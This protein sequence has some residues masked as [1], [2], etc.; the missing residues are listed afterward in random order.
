[1]T[2]RTLAW[3]VSGRVVLFWSEYVAS[4]IPL[5]RKFSLLLYCSNS[6]EWAIAF[7]SV[8]LIALLIVCASSSCSSL[9][10]VARALSIAVTMVFWTS[11]WIFAIKIGIEFSRDTLIVD[12]TVFCIV[13]SITLTISSLFSQ[14]YLGDLAQL[15]FYSHQ[16][17]LVVAL[18][19]A[20]GKLAVD[21]LFPAS[22]FQEFQFQGRQIQW[23]RAFS[24]SLKLFNKFI[25]TIR[26][27][28]YRQIKFSNEKNWQ[29]LTS[30][31]EH[32][33]D[34]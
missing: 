3:D 4:G 19:F 8:L 18:A 10:I 12:Y 9:F 15:R 27:I 13:A 30:K 2:L 28:I 26:L 5:M 22:Q 23:K 31:T 24:T 6:S 17:L 34:L 25:T 16:L 1:M 14:V 32:N 21:Q 11:S 20:P 7:R 33:N 29:S